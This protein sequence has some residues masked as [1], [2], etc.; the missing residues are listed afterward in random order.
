MDK[1]CPICFG[2]GWVCGNHPDRA[3]DA[4]LGCQCGAGIPCR[5]NDG[6]EMDA[7]AEKHIRPIEAMLAGKLPPAETFELNMPAGATQGMLLR[8]VRRI[9]EAL[10]AWIVETAPKLP[11]ARYAEYLTSIPQ[12][13]PAGSP[14]RPQL[15]PSWGRFL[16]GR[17]K[18]PPTEAA[19]LHE[20]NVGAAADQDGHPDYR[21]PEEQQVAIH[22]R[23][24]TM[25]LGNQ[26]CI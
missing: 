7:E 2:V 14:S 19:L 9:Q 1:N 24:A 5:C 26:N 8:E 23:P 10:V 15:S 13:Q 25:R 16:L 17:R 18:R 6:D 21:E 3:L 22:G 4:E 12:A 20:E 11:I